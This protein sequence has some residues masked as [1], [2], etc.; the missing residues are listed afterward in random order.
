MMTEN[1]WETSTMTETIKVVGDKENRLTVNCEILRERE[2][3]EF[4]ILGGGAVRGTT[5]ML[6][7]QK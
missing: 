4:R 1:P 7:G 6:G 5:K 2:K 3:S